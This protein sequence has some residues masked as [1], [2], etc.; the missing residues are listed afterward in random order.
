M[1]NQV[2]LRRRVPNILVALLLL[3]ATCAFAQS[4][5]P[6]AP[7]VP[8]LVKYA[9]V[10]RNASGEP[11]TGTVGVTFA[12]YA[13]EQGGSPLWIETQNVQ[14]DSQGRFSVSLGA[15]KS[16]GLPQ[17][18]FVSGEARWLGVQP[19]GQPEQ[20]RSQLI[21][22]PYAMKAGDAQTIGGLPASAFVL[23]A[24]STAPGNAS[25]PS[26]SS[27]LVPPALG[28]SG[29]VNFV[30]L[31]TPDGNTLGNSVMFQSGTGT[32]AKI[33]VN[34]NTPATTLDVK[35][36]GTIRG[37][38]TLP[39]TGNA[40]AAAGK[41]SQPLNWTASAFNSG[42][43]AAVSQNF[44]WQAEPVG[45]NTTTPSGKIN[46]LF[47]SGSNQPTETGLS[48]A[49]NGQITFS[50]GQTFPG[51][52]N[53]TITG[54][55]AGAGL[56]GGGT[57]GN[58]SLSVP[59]AGITNPM[60]QN[61]AVT[62]SPG[63]DLT[64]G[65]TISLGG[66][67][68]LNV[69]T[70]KV[71]QLSAANNFTNDQSVTGNITA[72]GTVTA[73]NVNAT[74]GFDLNGTLFASGSTALSNAF[75]GFGGNSAT[76]GTG[77]T[78]VGK[79]A[80]VT[81]TSGSG[82][83]AIGSSALESN[84]SGS[85]NEASGGAALT[86]NTTGSSNTADGADAMFNNTTGSSNTAVGVSALGNN[87]GGNSNTAVGADAG[88]PSGFFTTG[89]FDTFV[90]ASTSP[91]VNV[92][93]TNATAIGAQ[94][95]VDASN[96]MVLGSIN[97]VN[98]ATASTNVGIAITKPVF[99][100]QI[101]NA[102]DQPVF[103]FFRVE[104]PAVSGTTVTAGSFGGY[105]DFVIDSPG[106]PGGRFVVK[107]SGFVGIGA[108]GAPSRILT[109]GAGKGHALADGWD[110]YSSRRW[111]TNIHT[112]PSALDKV[113]HLRGVSYDRKDTGKHEIG[114]IA[115][116]VGAVVPEVVTYEANGKDAQ[117]VDYSRL[118]ALLI[119]AVKQQQKQI[120]LEAAR[121]KAQRAEIASLRLQLRK[122]T[123]KD[124]LLES[125]LTQLERNQ[126]NATKLAEY[127]QPVR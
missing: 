42:T 95:E 46:L 31:W 47:G 67:T 41:N 82:N 24:P 93:I 101:G 87:Q 113:E 21:S 116:E 123:Q 16:E 28:G 121:A 34:T 27:P 68:T 35:G 23:A 118:T 75:L 9:G 11:L 38:L 43:S 71:P 125:R 39:S 88:T 37:T 120:R 18:L 98:S 55:T 81:N 4:Q 57:S 29:T 110:V 30:P 65:G 103:G 70:T 107:E 15:T 48:L 61:S 122:Q 74:S 78:A 94:A 84:T 3:L 109:V 53:G 92:A 17:N 12:L 124:A 91:G 85:N 63:T 102:G 96:S 20:P 69:D 19:Q 25:Q 54:V 10:V 64:G 108:F 112:L 26:G 99:R 6:D 36:S 127:Q 44:R 60:L 22:V 90:G 52:G 50:T 1:S 14:V 104:G 72:T 119:E 32:S 8:H 56:S 86:F 117:S 76:T 33:G 111:K 2:S 105:G 5:S 45:N 73:V 80:L 115:E 51:T 49:S 40:T 13:A 62:V 100:L 66:S 106:I 114:V 59:S 58:V 7:T 77:N 89:S 126:G 79:P 83:T 97:G